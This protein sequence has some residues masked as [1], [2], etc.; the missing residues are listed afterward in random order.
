MGAKIPKNSDC[1]KQ[2]WQKSVNKLFFLFLFHILR[3]K[4]LIVAA[5]LNDAENTRFIGGK[6]MFQFQG[7]PTH[8]H[9]EI[10]FHTRMNASVVGNE[11]VNTD[12]TVV[13]CRRQGRELVGEGGGEQ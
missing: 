12:G 11:H 4:N 2:R 8:G 10:N 7:D 5:L 13:E 1:A 6:V 9:S 3:Q